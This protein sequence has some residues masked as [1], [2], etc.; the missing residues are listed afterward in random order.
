[1]HL[2]GS[3]YS[4]SKYSYVRGLQPYLGGHLLL[5]AAQAA[6]NP[7][8]AACNPNWVTRLL[9]AAA[10]EESLTLTLTLT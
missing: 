9:L 4:C 6:C 1:M 8:C 2:V 5:A 7:M 10:Q 3:E